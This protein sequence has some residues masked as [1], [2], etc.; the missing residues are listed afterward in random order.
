MSEEQKSLR[1]LYKHFYLNHTRQ[2]F[3]GE[4]KKAISTF[5]KMALLSLNMDEMWFAEI[6]ITE[7][8]KQ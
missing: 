3:N 5:E 1:H 2:I 4:A 8:V 6:E 7:Y